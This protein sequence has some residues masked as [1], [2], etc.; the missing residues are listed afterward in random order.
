MKVV[1]CGG[2]GFI[3]QHLAHHLL[4]KGHE[5]SILDRNQS[6]MSS[7]DQNNIHD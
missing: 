2:G 4:D 1:I 6:R 7:Y 5:V 3:G